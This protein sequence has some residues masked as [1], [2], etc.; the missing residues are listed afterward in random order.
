MDSW[1]SSGEISFLLSR[2]LND[3]FILTEIKLWQFLISNKCFFTMENIILIFYNV[4]K[5]YE[6]E[7]EVVGFVF[8]LN[9]SFHFWTV[10]WRSA[11]GL[12]GIG[13]L[14]SPLTFL[15]PFLF[16]Q[17]VI[18]LSWHCLWHFILLHSHRWQ[19]YLISLFICSLCKP[20]LTTSHFISDFFL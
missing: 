1:L 15:H 18:I 16:H 12:E 7:W 5:R 13:T 4:K 10:C 19:K 17:L 9:I 11:M 6:K 20:M 8:V 3:F 14:M 2:I